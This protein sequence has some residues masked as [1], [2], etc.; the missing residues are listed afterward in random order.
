MISIVQLHPLFSPTNSKIGWPWTEPDPKLAE[1]RPDGSIWPRISII[2]PSY[3][4]GRFLEETIRSVLMQGYPNLEYFVL[5]GGSQDES[6]EILKKYSTQLSYWHSRK[7]KGQSD[8][9]N[10]GLRMTT[11]EIVAWINSDDTY[12]PGIFE[13]IVKLFEQKETNLVYGRAYFIDKDSKITGNYPARTIENGWRRFR[14]WRGWPVPQPTV[15]FRRELLEKYGYLNTSLQ[16]GLDYEFFIRLSCFL[17][18]DYL[19]TPLA[20]YRLHSQSKTGEW[21]SNKKLF[22]RETLHVNLRYAPWFFPKNWRLWFEWIL[23]VSKQNL[24]RFLPPFKKW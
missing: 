10:Q 11:G 23:H 19:D 15:F 9:I 8:A 12:L 20:N 18:F 14:Y 6:L 24:K 13:K 3:N 22:Y 16:Y 5:D 4:Q 17:K 7:D 1:N 21:A 2:T